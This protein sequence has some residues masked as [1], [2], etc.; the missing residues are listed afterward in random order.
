M[1]SVSKTCPSGQEIKDAAW[2]FAEPKGAAG[3]IKD[4][5]AFGTLDEYFENAG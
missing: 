4:Y 3:H 2:F 1:D 5:V